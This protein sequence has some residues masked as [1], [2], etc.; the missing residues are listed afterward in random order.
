M[1]KLDAFCDLFEFLAATLQSAPLAVT[2][3]YWGQRRALN[4]IDESSFGLI[5]LCNFQKTFFP[6][7]VFMHKCEHRLSLP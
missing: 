4:N 3:G 5:N 6:F 1:L 2:A 7:F